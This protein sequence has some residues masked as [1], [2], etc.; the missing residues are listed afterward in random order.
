M[1]KIVVFSK[2]NRTIGLLGKLQCLIPRSALPTKNK[3]FARP[4]LGYGDII[5]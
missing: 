5:Y 2:I 4:H 1:A 3:T